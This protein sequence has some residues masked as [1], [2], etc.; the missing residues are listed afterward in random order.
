MVTGGN[1]L[2]FPP[3]FERLDAS[4]GDVLLN[5]GKGNFIERPEKTGFNSRGIVREI[6]K[7]NINGNKQSLFCEMMI[8]RFFI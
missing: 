2:G 6:K 1:Q 3:Q 5:D 8:I 4:F 7:I